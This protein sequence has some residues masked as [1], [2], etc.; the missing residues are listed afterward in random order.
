MEEYTHEA[1]LLPP[2]GFL[3][4]KGNPFETRIYGYRLRLTKSAKGTIPTW[5]GPTIIA[6]GRQR[7]DPDPL[8]LH[9]EWTNKLPKGEPHIISP[10][11]QNL[12]AAGY[13]DVVDTTLHWAYALDDATVDGELFEYSQ[14][15]IKEKGVPIVPH[16]HGGHTANGFDGNPEYFF[17]RDFK[18]KGPQWTSEIYRYDNDQPAGT[19]W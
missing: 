6:Q 10:N 5:P 3:A 14:Y 18:I 19:V 4:T 9:I 7:G 16:V 1:G 17:T 11:P 8:P 12:N 15:S 2:G 13:E